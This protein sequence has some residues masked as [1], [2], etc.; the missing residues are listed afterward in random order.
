[1]VNAMGQTDGCSVHKWYDSAIGLYVGWAVRSGSFSD[2]MPISNES[3]DATLI[4]SGEEFPELGLRGQLTRKG[5]S[6]GPEE[7]SYLIHVYEEDPSFPAGLNGRFHGVIADRKLKKILLF[8]DRYCMHRLYYHDAKDAFYFAAEAK[9]LLAVRPELREWDLR[10]LG[11]FIACGCTL[12]NRSL[13]RRVG[14]LPGGSLWIFENGACRDKRRYFSPEDWEGQEHLAPDKY[15]SELRRVFSTNLPRFFQGTQK[16]G[17]SLTGGLDSRM[18]MAWQ[19]HETGTLPCYTFGSPRRECRDVSIARQVAAVC[20]Q[21]YQ[22]ISI[23]GDFFKRFGEYA[24]KTVY[25]TDGCVDVSRTPDL[26][27]NERAS[28]IAP[29]RMTGNYG[30][31]LF[32]S[33]RAFKVREPLPGLLAPELSPYIQQAADTYRAAMKAHP[34]SFA[35]FKQAPWHHYGILALENTQVSMRS[36]FLDNDLVKTVFRA[37]ESVLTS[38]TV[39]ME[40]IRDGNVKLLSIPTDRGLNMDRRLWSRLLGIGSR[41]IQEFFFKAEYAYDIGMPQWLAVTDHAVSRL[42]LEQMFLGRH[43]VFHFR[44]WYRDS[45]ADYVKDLLLDGR[46]LSRPHLSQMAVRRVVNSHVDGT[47]NWANEIHLLLSL[48]LIERL[49]LSQG[50]PQEPTRA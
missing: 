12:E 42:E 4:F 46:T 7:A 35:V 28:L 41:N 43:K 33:I 48:E 13:F 50:L 15:G 49:L 25:L 18:I 34:T 10:A 11:E 31:E 14:I 22:V 1:M 36:P 47:G 8:N 20:G 24:E 38:A 44:I 9:C 3:S 17:M 40:L 30:S 19:R 2:G 6:L 29:I 23:G 5:H 21:P 26:Y 16:I 39:S 45:I 32:R 37:P 27:L